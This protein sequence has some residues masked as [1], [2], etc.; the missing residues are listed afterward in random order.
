MNLVDRA[1]KIITSPKTEWQT[2]ASE[3]PNIQQIFVGYV[4]PLALIPAVAHIIGWGLIGSGIIL[5]YSW[6]IATGLVQF[7]LAFVAVYVTAFVVDALAPSFGSQKNLGRAVQLVAYSATPAWV[8][9][10]LNIIPYLG[11]LG[12]L[13]GLYSIYLLYLGLPHT[14]K[15]PQ[16][17]VAVYLI[18][19]IVVLIL[20]YVIIG[21]I[22]SSLFLAIFGLSLLGVTG[23]GL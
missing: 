22:L 8:A 21:A 2:I 7:F 6:G 17:K 14:M 5:S 15:T 10:I 18:V 3:E 20:V 11:W 16:D 19:S 12:S 4:F 23:T 13:L 9:G 1:K